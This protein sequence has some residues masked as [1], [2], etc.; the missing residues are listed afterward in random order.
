MTDDTTSNTRKVLHNPS[1][2][3]LWLGRIGI[4]FA[5]QME[6]VAVGWQMYALTDSTFYLGL[7]GLAQ[8]LPMVALTLVVGQVV[9][10]FDRRR[11]LQVCTL[12]EAGCVGALALGSYQGWLTAHWLLL[13]VALI[14]ASHAFEGP[15]LQSLLPS[16]IP[17]E[18]FPTAAAISTSAMQ[19]SSIIGPAIGGFLYTINASVVYTV[20][21][22]CFLFASI[23]VLRIRY[24]RSSTIKEPV[25]RKSIFA[26]LHFIWSKPLVLG[27]ISLDLFAV[28]LGGATALLPVFAKDILHTG[29]MGLGLLRSAPAIG[30]LITSIYLARH[31]IQHHVGKVMFNA[32]FVFGLATILFGVSTSF[33]L[34]LFA[35]LVLGGSDIISVVIRHTLV[36]LGTPDEMRGRVSAVNSLFIGTSNQ[37]GEFESGLTASLFGVVPAVVLGGL[38]TIAV[39]FVW[40]KLFPT[41]KNADTIT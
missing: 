31:P 3:R 20:S 5:Y 6:G 25:N 29:P 30:A 4:S 33:Y 24:D 15:S 32:V 1:F 12:I 37:L 22:G 41:L 23:M 7:V 8:F 39:V 26:G 10:R 21:A 14:G 17:R 9:D 35:L 28:L 27:A 16:I 2:L 36:Q 38:G 40:M 19:T 18:L 13:I 11:I 34:S